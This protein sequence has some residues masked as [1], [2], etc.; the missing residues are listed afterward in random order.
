MRLI[1]LFVIGAIVHFCA[2]GLR[3]VRY[4]EQEER[5]S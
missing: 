3:L 2:L 5:E 1:D 4:I